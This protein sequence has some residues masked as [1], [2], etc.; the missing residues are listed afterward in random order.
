MVRSTGNEMNDVAEG[1]WDD[2]GSLLGVI[3]GQ[4]GKIAQKRAKLGRLEH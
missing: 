3:S 2:R 4:L 1:P